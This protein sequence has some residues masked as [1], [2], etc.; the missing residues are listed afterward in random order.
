LDLD[1]TVSELNME[2]LA[3]GNYIMLT[4]K[5]LLDNAV[6]VAQQLTTRFLLICLAVDLV[7]LII[8]ILFSVP[9]CSSQPCAS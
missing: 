2:K 4:K 5:R 3:F 1:G 8:D 7:S 9:R 6:E